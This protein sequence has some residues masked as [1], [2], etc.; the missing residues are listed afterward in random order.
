MPRRTWGLA[1]AILLLDQAS[2]WLILVAVMRPP[3]VIEVTEFLNLVLVYNRGVSFGLFNHAGSGMQA[4]LLIVIALVIVAALIVWSRRSEDRWVHS[5][6]G[7]VI[8]GAIG[9]VLDRLIHP[10]VVDFIDLHAAGYHWPAF[11]VADSA[12]VA[13][14]VIILAQTLF[15]EGSSGKR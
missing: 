1:L 15:G 3:R 2:K 12:I 14:V 9:N 7:L 4:T 11:N 10:G 13:G 5:A 8:G 6:I